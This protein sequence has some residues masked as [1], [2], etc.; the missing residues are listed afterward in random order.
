MADAGYPS[1]ASMILAPDKFAAAHP[2]AVKAFVEATAAGWDA[3]L[4]GD[5]KPADAMIM[6]E[7]PE[8]TADVLAQARDKMRSYGIVLPKGAAPADTGAMTD[9]KWAQTFKAAADL[10][11]APKD[12]DVRKAYALQFLPKTAQPPPAK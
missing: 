9:A 12:L 4:N 11:L 3:Y 1:Y 2:E 6:K 10:G 8:Q 5:P 7:N